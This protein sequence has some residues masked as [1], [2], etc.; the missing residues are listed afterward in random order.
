MTLDSRKIIPYILELFQSILHFTQQMQR[1]KYPIAKYNALLSALMKR[2]YLFIVYLAYINLLGGAL[3]GY[4]LAAVAGALSTFQN[5][6]KHRTAHLSKFASSLVLSLVASVLLFGGM[7]GALLGG[8][9]S[10]LVGRKISVLIIV[11]VTVIG[12]VLSSAVPVF[13]VVIVGRFI[14]GLGVGYATVL[15]PMYVTEMVEPR[16]RG[17]LASLFQIGLNLGIIYA[18]VMG[19][20]FMNSSIAWRPIF[21][22]S[23]VITIGLFFALLIMPESTVWLNK[24]R[25]T[26]ASSAETETTKEVEL[27]ERDSEEKNPDEGPLEATVPAIATTTV[28]TVEVTSNNSVNILRAIRNL[29]C[30]WKNIKNML[31]GIVIACT[32]QLTGINAITFFAPIMFGNAGWSRLAVLLATLGLGFGHLI[33]SIVCVLIVD[34]V[35]R[36]PLMIIGTLLKVVTMISLGFVF[37]FAKTS[38]AAPLSVVLMVIFIAGFNLGA[39]SLMY[40]LFNELFLSE[41]DVKDLAIGILSAT[42]WTAA[43]ILALFYLPLAEEIGHSILFWIFGGLAVVAVI[44]LILFLPETAENRK[45][46]MEYLKMIR[47][48]NS[49]KE[50]MQQQKTDETEEEEVVSDT[51]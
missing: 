46:W 44:I 38:V 36:K 47:N 51:V 19:I 35:G 20:A 50:E 25:N 2:K 12:T 29:C 41:P 40:V 17:Q 26:T 18:Y 3:F 23:G 27:E 15:C 42:Q 8:P 4:N 7:I 28:E 37:M 14:E 24:R 39:G 22:L 34:R 5:D 33:S 43:L 49:T 1:L 31:L 32:A 9:I 6:F 10:D 48:R 13:E 11:V 45:N 21:G 30:K 16:R